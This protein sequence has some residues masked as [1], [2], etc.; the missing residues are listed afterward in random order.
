[1]N[2]N[3]FC[4]YSFNIREKIKLHGVKRFNDVQDKNDSDENESQG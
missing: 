2:I 1:M 3:V 4:F